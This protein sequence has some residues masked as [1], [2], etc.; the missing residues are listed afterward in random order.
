M[1]KKKVKKKNKKSFLLDTSIFIE[2]CKYPSIQEFLE[3][4]RSGGYNLV[5]AFFVLYEYKVG[6]IMGLIDF[7]FMVKAYDEID[8]ALVKWSEKWGR[9]SKN[10][11][12]YMAMI[13]RIKKS[14]N[15]S[16]IKGF[17]EKLEYVIFDE[18]NNF[19]TFLDGMVGEFQ[20][21]EIVK[22][23]IRTK[24]DFSNFTVLYNKRKSIPLDNFWEKNIDSLDK[25]IK[26]KEL[27][28]Q[29]NKIHKH[30]Q[31]IKASYIKANNF[32]CNKTIGDAVI[33]TDCASKRTIL[34]KDKSF[35]VLCN[36]LNKK[37]E[38]IKVEDYSD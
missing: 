34:S 32:Y 25:I 14:I 1:G 9:A 8:K 11:L 18:A 5:S 17:L 7:Y 33:A 12:I 19:D 21:D 3:K 28:K 24:E 36:A 30:L 29:Y 15:N 37:S 16:D 13:L 6:F 22:F 23:K 20:N 27:E 2:K 4:K 35:S 10:A 26:S 31:D 38:I